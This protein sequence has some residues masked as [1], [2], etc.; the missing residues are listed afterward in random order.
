MGV[1]NFALD[2]CIVLSNTINVKIVD[3]IR[4]L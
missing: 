1:F 2:L 4:E 3:N